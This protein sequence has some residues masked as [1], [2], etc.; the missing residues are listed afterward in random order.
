MSWIGG[1]IA[2]GASLLNRPSGPKTSALEKLMKKRR[3][4]LLSKLGPGIRNNIALALAANPVGFNSNTYT[5]A[6]NATKSVAPSIS[7]SIESA[8]GVAGSGGGV[9]ITNSIAEQ[10]LQT[11]L[12][13]RVPDIATHNL[14]FLQDMFNEDSAR[15]LG[16]ANSDYL[17]AKADADSRLWSGIGGA[18]ASVDW[19]KVFA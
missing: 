12:W 11:A 4:L 13:D 5:S 6:T 2:L 18:F 7:K 10:G 14:A 17:T 3:A 19:G 16:E 15:R 8:T 1:A 9:P